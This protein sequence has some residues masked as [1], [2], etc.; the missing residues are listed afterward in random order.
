M[1]RV[2]RAVYDLIKRNLFVKGLVRFV[3]QHVAVI[4]SFSWLRKKW[5]HHP[6]R[7]WPGHF[8]G[9]YD[10]CPWSFDDRY[11]LAHA[12]S[13]KRGTGSTQGTLRIRCLDEQTGV[14]RELGKTRAWNWQQGSLLQWVGDTH[15]VAF[16]DC[17]NGAF[18]TRMVDRSGTPIRT[19]PFAS[20]GLSPDGRYAASYS[21]TRL[22][23]VAPGYAYRGELTLADREACPK[24]DGLFVHDVLTGS[25]VCLIS[26]YE[27]SQYAPEA[28]MQ[29]AVHYVNHVTFSPSS[30]SLV[31]FHRWQVPN[32]EWTRM[33]SYHIPS[34]RWHLFK[35]AGML[36]HVAWQ[37]DTH[38]MAWAR[39]PN[40]SSD[41][42]VIF[43]DGT[44]RMQIVGEKTITS[45]GHPTWGPDG[46]WFLSDTYPNR[47]RMTTLYR[48]DLPSGRNEL[49]RLY[50]P[51][52]FSGDQRVDLH[53]RLN[54][55]GT[56]ACFDAVVD[57]SRALCTMDLTRPA[58]ASD[59]CWHLRSVA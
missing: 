34:R 21:F 49:A 56:R 55:S 36:S 13:D 33:I 2:E 18:I 39:L 10:I 22:Q 32:R 7:Y 48:F 53:P 4:L 47:S 46:T 11:L 25:R 1:H 28:S 59:E 24:G 58:D 52:R 54:R 40:E 42:Q 45:D 57:G 31:F 8:F 26:L 15:S 20:A 37:D 5:A 19:L 38:V 29:E 27:L 6:V 43:E 41:A 3:Y 17:E 30:D 23:R 35:T 14:A 16:N 51:F 44:D 50:H 12:Y 9:Y